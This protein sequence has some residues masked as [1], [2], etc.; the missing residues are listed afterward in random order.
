MAE[1]IALESSPSLRG[2]VAMSRLGRK[3]LMTAESILA[4]E[5]AGLE[6]SWG[7]GTG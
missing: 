6:A 2:L 4:R 5:W 3:S 1:G 7:C